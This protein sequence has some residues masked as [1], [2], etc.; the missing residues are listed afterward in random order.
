MHMPLYRRGVFYHL[1]VS[2]SPGGYSTEAAMREMSLPPSLSD[3][4]TP[5]AYDRELETERPLLIVRGDL[6]SP[7]EKEAIARYLDRHPTLYHPVSSPEGP[8]LLRTRS[9]R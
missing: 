7:G 6:L 5:A 8:V 4:M 9:D 1:A 3:R 2:S